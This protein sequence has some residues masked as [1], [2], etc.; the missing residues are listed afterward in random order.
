MRPKGFVICRRLFTTMMP[1]AESTQRAALATVAPRRIAAGRAVARQ[2]KDRAM[3]W[4]QIEGTWTELKGRFADRWRKLTEVDLTT[5]SGKRDKLAGL[6][7]RR[8]GVANE[9]VEKQIAV[10]ERHL[11]EAP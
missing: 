1:L 11:A 10:F 7:Q 9:Y 6:L 3:T 5:I 8:Y 2:R 4:D